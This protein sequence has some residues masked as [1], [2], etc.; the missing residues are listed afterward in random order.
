MTE[1]TRLECNYLAEP[2]GIA[3]EPP[4][5]SWQGP[6][7]C[8]QIHDGSALCFA[9]TGKV[10]SPFRPDWRPEP[11]TAYR[12]TLDGDAAESH[13]ETAFADDADWQ[14]AQWLADPWYSAALKAPVSRFETEFMIDRLDDRPARLY[15]SSLGV[16]RALLNGQPVG[17]ATLAPGAPD[18]YTRTLY[19]TYDVGSL[20]QAGRNHIAIDLADGWHASAVARIGDHFCKP[21]YATPNAVIARLDRFAPKGVETLAATNSAWRV[22]HDGPYRYSDIYMGEWFDA[23]RTFRDFGQVAVIA[24]RIRLDAR[25]GAPVRRIQTLPPASKVRRKGATIVDFGQNIAGRERITFCAPRGARVVIRHGEMLEADGGLYTANLR[26]AEATTIIIASGAE[27]TFEPEFT[28]Y[29]FRYLEVSGTAEFEI[30]AQVL[31][32]DLA[33]VG[34]IRCDHEL[35]NRL[36]QNV[37]WGQRGNFLDIPTDCPQRDERRGWLGDAQVFIPAA[38]YNMHA[39][40]FF[41]KWLDDVLSCRDPQGRYPNFAPNYRYSS[42]ATHFG[43][44]GWADAGIIC[45]WRLYLVYGDRRFLEIHAEAIYRWIDIQAEHSDRGL[46]R[47]ARFGDWLQLEAKTPEELVSTAYFTHGANLAMQIAGVLGDPAAA[48]RMKRHREL[49]KAAFRRHFLD[50]SGQLTVSTQCAAAMALQFELLEAPEIPDAV[51]LLVHDIVALRDTHLTTG[52]LGTPLL[53]HALSSH[54]ELELAYRLLEQTTYPSWLYPVTQGA[55]TIWERWNSWNR[56]TGFGDVAM[57]SFNH[58]AYGA[59]ADWLYSVAGGI[60][61]CPAAPGFREFDLAP[62]PGGSLKQF[63]ASYDSPAG[64]IES[65]WQRHGDETEYCVHVPQGTLAH[66]SLPDGTAAELPGGDYRYAISNPILSSHEI[67]SG[68]M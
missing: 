14:P 27:E 53:L 52:F 38:L 29:G 63:Q 67:G 42:L 22:A 62:R 10:H 16:Y 39:A 5:L 58:Y 64:R 30:T 3:V 47:H 9:T 18:F 26:D 55:T 8:V 23:T 59:V 40:S 44:S 31:H 13:F 41:R 4:T 35:I 12:W 50:A 48:E 33:P 1:F 49:G 68:I 15:L 20:L 21:F 7:A 65:A 11:Q 46:C 66:L 25:N 60:R 56:D 17:D 2:L 24:P 61:P 32:S 34:A 28:F 37:Q 45:P 57:N 19:Q 54:G 43:V 51:R 6:A 36:M